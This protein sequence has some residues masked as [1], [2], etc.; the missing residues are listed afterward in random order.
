MKILITGACG[1]V[2]RA[3]T[4]ELEASGTRH[5]LRLLDR[6]PPEQATVFQPGSAERAKVPLET[7]WPFVQA[8]ITDP[9]A[10]RQAMEGVDAV[11]HLAAA[12]S[13]VP[14]RGVE[15]FEANALGTFVVLDAARQAGVQRFLCASSINAFGTFY[16]RLSGKPVVYSQMPLDETF[17]PVPE[18][19]YSL[20]KW[21]NEGTCAAFTRAYG[22]TTAAFRFAGVWTNDQYE[23]KQKKGL[24]PTTRWSDDLYQWV[25]VADIARG[26]RQ[27]LEAPG[28]PAH[29]VYTLSAADTRCPEPTRDLLGRFRPDLLE[30][31][32]EPLE[33]RA[34]LLSIER[35]RCAFGYAPQYRLG[36]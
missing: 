29:G 17:A 35:A 12:V 24:E 3:L 21:V 18:D 31:L 33:G 7:N 19:P 10:V 1:F 27:A 14:E 4:T 22:M 25:H 32:T 11:V 9:E 2:A 13:G 30:T 23:D 5:E 6:T 20:S 15:T 34:P 16:W 26:L 36:S 8:E 28:L